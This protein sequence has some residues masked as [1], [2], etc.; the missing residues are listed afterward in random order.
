MA[1]NIINKGPFSVLLSVYAKEE[2]EYFR[3]A[4]ES[5]FQ[6]T[7]R[8]DDVVVVED[9]RLT[10]ALEGVVREFESRYPELH[11][12]RFEKNRGLGAALNDGLKYCRHELVARADSDDVCKPYRFE[13][14]LKVFEE[15][16]DYDLCG[17][18]VDEFITDISDVVSVRKAPET[19]EENYLFGKKRCPVNHPTAMYKK[20]SVEA[21]G[22]YLT[23]YF[24]EDFYLW[25]KMLNNG[26][27]FYN[28]Q[29]SLV[30]F[31]YDPDT[32][33]RR[34]G[35][36]YAYDEAMTQV[37]IHRIG[38]TTWTRMMKNI[39]MRTTVRIMPDWM[40]SWVYKNLLR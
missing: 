20:S 29:E 15:H 40:R 23:E 32:Y 10:D 5:L 4:L 30:W 26:C 6:Q 37:Q 11:V 1:S 3:Q 2:P 28:L 19:P 39:A 27:K 7:V 8:S 17:S 24:P 14:Q 31:R 18:W 13:H 22:G 35:W 38:Y 21:V 34:G 12:V 9:G 36:K 16:P 25:A 33:K